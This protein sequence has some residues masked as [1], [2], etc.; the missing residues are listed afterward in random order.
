MYFKYFEVIIFL[1]TLQIS[2]LL[3]TLL[4]QGGL[5]ASQGGMSKTCFR[6]CLHETGTKS[7]WGHFVSVIVLFIV[8]VYVIPPAGPSQL[9]SDQA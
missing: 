5:G 7:N 8:D 2:I 9:A 3:M 6:P 4:L 1:A